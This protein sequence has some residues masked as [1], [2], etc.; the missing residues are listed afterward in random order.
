MMSGLNNQIVVV[1]AGFMGAGIAQVCIQKKM[2]CLLIDTDKESL[3]RAVK[4]I[5]GSLSKLYQ[6]G[7]IDTE[8]ENALALLDTKSS[9]N[10]SRNP[11][12]VIETVFE[13][14]QLKKDVLKNVEKIV[15]S[16]TLLATNT[17]SIPISRLASVL[18]HPG[19]FLGLHFFGPVPLME[20]V[21]VVKGSGTSDESFL[22]GTTFVKALGKYP[23]GV[24]KDI[25]GFA[26]NR[27]FSAAFRECQELVEQGVVSVEDIDAGMRMGYGWRTGPFQIAD[28]AG[29]DTVLKIGKS[30]KKLGE[31][32]LY[33]DS[34]LIEA[35]VKKG[36]MGRKSGQGFY[37]YD[38]DMP[39]SQ[40]G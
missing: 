35:L 33:S 36:C 5:S 32:Q 9:I 31:K 14:E 27:I 4:M 39:A 15:S 30:M 10:F 38:A 7:L 8:P 17:S 28:N 16:S 18:S 37:S 3:D 24:K 40:K 25:P 26:M 12:W 19:R 29:L 6:K 22:Q 1:G 20:L 11:S 34:D 2:P 21:E 13:D 23:V